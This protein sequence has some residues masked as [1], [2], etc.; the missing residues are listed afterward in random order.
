MAKSPASARPLSTL[1][2]ADVA[3]VRALSELMREYG[4]AE[5]ELEDGR[6]RLRL[7]RAQIRAAA[8]ETTEAGTS[9][10]PAAKGQEPPAAERQA[11]TA[12]P[13]GSAPALGPNQ[14]L[15]P[16]PMVGTFYR[17]SAPD[18]PLLVE[19]GDTVR[20]GQPLC[21]IEAMKMMN[22]IEAEAIARVVKILCEN[23]GRV[24]YGQPL[25]VLEKP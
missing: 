4:L 11:P 16:S 14:Y 24:E 15:L 23:G 5:L 19:E 20:R 6:R 8:A 1:P 13:D 3:E 7:V 10:A 25:M 22:E 9:A 12:A 17:A 18:A 2:A 21:I